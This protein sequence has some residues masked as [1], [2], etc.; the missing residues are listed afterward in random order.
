MAAGTCAAELKYCN[1]TGNTN[2]IEDL[3]GT[4]QIFVEYSD[5]DSNGSCVNFAVAGG[6]LNSQHCSYNA[7]GANFIEGTGSFFHADTITLG[8]HTIAGTI[9]ETKNDWQPYASSGATSIGTSRGTAAFSTN[10]FQVTDGF[11]ELLSPTGIT[12]SDQAA[13]TTVAE[14]SG[15]FVIANITLTLPFPTVDG[16]EVAFKVDGAFVVVLQ[17]QGGTLIKIA[18]NTSTIGGTA[19]STLD[20]DAVS[21]TWRNNSNTWIANSVIGNWLLA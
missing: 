1:M 10:D 16:V 21:F 15:S 8:S 2:G 14:F 7:N 20:G 6:S 19:T 13:N 11:V 5:I 17:A 9:T 4:A 3:T 12:W 18:N